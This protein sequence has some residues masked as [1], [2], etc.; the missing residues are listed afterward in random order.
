MPSWPHAERGLPVIV[1]VSVGPAPHNRALR[2]TRCAAAHDRA[3][4]DELCVAAWRR[5]NIL[6]YVRATNYMGSHIDVGP[7]Y[8]AIAGLTIL[9]LTYIWTTRSFSLRLQ[10]STARWDDELVSMSSPLDGDAERSPK[11]R[12]RRRRLSA[13]RTPLTAE[14][15]RSEL[16]GRK[17]Q[18]ALRRWLICL[19]VFPQDVEDLAQDTTM[20][21][22]GSLH[23][24]DLCRP[25]PERW[26][27]RI[28]VHVREPPM[29][30]LD[31][32]HELLDLGFR[33]RL[34][35][36]EHPAG[37]CYPPPWRR[38][39]RVLE[40]ASRCGRATPRT[41]ATPAARDGAR[42]GSGRSGRRPGRPRESSRPSVCPADA[43]HCGTMP[44]HGA[45][46]HGDTSSRP[47]ERTRYRASREVRPLASR[48]RPRWRAACEVRRRT[49]RER[50]GVRAAVGEVVG[51]TSNRRP[52]GEHPRL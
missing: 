52:A 1:A 35:L 9:M 18:G 43:R 20:A 41:R 51:Q 4:C 3:N 30:R 50:R 38:Q 28:A 34:A 10:T 16:C 49:Q 24:H 13:P 33:G 11:P 32:L 42:A 48:R 8:L 36:W 25:R 31:V 29:E 6:G 37:G 22:L 46:C 44:R 2:G 12:R 5:M 39:A 17:V 15:V 45:A 47:S 14:Q 40:G 27:N 21:A 26:L 7:M 23:T 19:R